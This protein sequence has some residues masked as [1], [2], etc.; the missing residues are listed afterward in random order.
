[1]LGAAALCSL[2]AMRSGA[3]LV[4]VGV[5]QSLSIAL[6]KKI[7]SVVMTMPLAET[8][9]QSISADAYRQIKKNFTR[10]NA[11]AVGPGMSEHTSTQKFIRTLV[12]ECPIPMVID[13]DGLNALAGH[14]NILRRSSTPKVLTPHPGEMARLTGE[15]KKT[16]ESDRKK[17]A[18][19]FTR[20]SNCVV[21]LKGHRTVVASPS[22]KTYIN[23]TGSPGMATAGSGDVLTGMIAAFL[24]QG[25]SAF[26]AAKWGAYLHGKAGELA[27][28]A[29]TPT[30][31]I[32]SDIIEFI[33]EVFKK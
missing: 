29:K 19:E 18:V 30:A 4:T 20:Q 12:A 31:M 7:A 9:E 3:G 11:V 17:A 8:P 26:D 10:F 5:P 28:R 25:L 24:G 27:A 2:A 1:M 32:A 33:P 6:Q 16:I 22:G 14:G 13:A 21:L 15:K 23:L